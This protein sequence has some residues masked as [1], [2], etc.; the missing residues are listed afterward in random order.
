MNKKQ[1]KLLAG[2]CSVVTDPQAGVTLLMAVIITATLSL[3]SVTVAFLAI[4]NIRNSR[5]VL[6]SEP[7][8]TA[9]FSAG[10][11]GV[12]HLKRAVTLPNCSVTTSGG[13]DTLGANGLWSA[14]NFCRSNTAATI[15]I[16]A[17]EDYV[18]YLYNPD[19]PNGDVDLKELSPTYQ[20]LMV[21]NQTG[22]ANVEIRTSRLD[23]TP[24]GIQP[25]L[26]APGDTET[27]NNLEGP[28]DIDNRMKIILRSINDAQ[29]LVNT[30]IGMPTLPTVDAV[31]CAQRGEGS[32][33]S[34]SAA[35]VF[36]RRIQVTVPQ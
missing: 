30:N 27:I 28:E 36:N 4:Q 3:I 11:E 35:E 23:G 22:T 14:R 25:I 16:V 10:E 29:V 15:N 33:T 6:L 18:F 13:S 5:A 21:T 12:W 34:C 2:N 24:V 31:G 26:A 1:H 32:G 8:I 7:A 20:S 17:G 9:A 19:N